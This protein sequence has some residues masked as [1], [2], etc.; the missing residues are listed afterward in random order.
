MNKVIAV[1]V[2]FNTGFEIK[3]N[4]KS[5]LTQ[6]EKIILVDNS[7]DS[8]TKKLINSIRDNN[9]EE[10]HVI[11]N[12]ENLGLAKAQNIG[13]KEALT[14]DPDWI[15]IFD[16]DSELLP[17]SISNMMSIYKKLSN[18]ENIAMLVPQVIERNI[19]KKS[20]FIINHK[21][22]IKRVSFDKNELVI[23]K[24]LTAI[25]SGSLVKADI[26]KNGLYMDEELFIDYIDID[27]SLK[28]NLLGYEIVAIK[29]SKLFHT[30]G[31]RKNFYFF[32]KRFIL[33]N[34]KP[35]RRYYIFRNR[36]IVW[37]K[38]YKTNFNY[39]FYDFIVSIIEAF[40][41][42]LFEN[43][44]LENFKNMIKGIKDGIFYCKK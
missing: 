14:F 26:F 7:S 9:P 1:I 15:M 34:H 20:I 10:I 36:F 42:L 35:F 22:F 33:N 16:D 25:A 21:P 18:N 2:T 5:F 12:H 32:G 8:S 39:V 3:D 43:S 23:R 29:N 27:F 38:Y 17:D 13:I 41:I 11:L 6:V 28:I 40:K 24:V 37:N 4:I 31:N 30:L 19:S 44:R